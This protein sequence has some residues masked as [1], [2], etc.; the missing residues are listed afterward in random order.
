MINTLL[1][2]QEGRLTKLTQSENIDYHECTKI[3]LEIGAEIETLKEKGWA[4]LCIS[5][6]DISKTTE[7]SYILTPS[8][9]L[10]S[11]DD[12]GMILIDR[13]Y[14]YDGTYMAPEL[15]YITTL[16]SKVY[17]T[18]VYF[19]LKQLTLDVLGVDTLTCIYPTKLYFLIERC[20][21]EDPKERIFIFI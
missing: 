18:S 8:M 2:G 12:N 21:T 9:D 13:P 5:R 16:P 7:G 17:Y 14:T 11:C 10:F 6:E 3:I 19:S 15:K 4:L 20:S 1:D